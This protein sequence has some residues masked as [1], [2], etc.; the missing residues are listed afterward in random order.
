M[1]SSSSLYALFTACVIT[2]VYLLIFRP[3]KDAETLKPRDA[4]PLLLLLVSIAGLY[5]ELVLIRWMGTEV[6]IFA[7]VQNLV[8]IACFLGFGVGCFQSDKPGTLMPVLDGLVVLTLIVSLPSPVWQTFMLHLSNLLS[9]SADAALWGDHMVVY[10]PMQY[11][12]YFAM[13]VVVVAALLWVIAASMMPLGR[14]IGYCFD[15][16]KNIT[17]TYSVNLVGSLIG[18]WVLVVLAALSMPPAV[19]VTLAFL[20]ILA[21]TPK[22]K[23]NWGVGLLFLLP[24]LIM[25]QATSVRTTWSPYQK[26]T[27]TPINNESEYLIETNNAGYMTISNTQPAFLKRHPGIEKAYR[28]TAYD[29]PFRFA[30]PKPDVLIVG[31]GAGNDASAALRAGASHVDAVE[32]DPVIYDLG[33]RLHPDKP[34]QSAKVDVIINDAR[35]FLRRSDKK[36]DAIIFGLLDSHTEVSGYTNIRVDNYVYTKEAFEQARRLLKPDG[37]LALKFEVR[38]PWEWIGQRFYRT[39]TDVF[40]GRKPLVYAP[41]TAGNMWSGTV[42]LESNSDKLWQRAKQP[43]LKKLIADNPPLFTPEVANAPESSTDDWPYPYHRGRTIPQTY[44]TVSALLLV[45]AF[46]MVRKTFDVRE[47]QTWVMFLLG[48]GFML[49]ETQLVSRLSL[50]FGTTWIVN[51]IAISAVLLVLVLANV[52]LETGKRPDMRKPA[53]IVLI[54]SLIANYFVPWERMPF[55]PW[56]VG[57]ILSAAF[58]VSILMAGVIFTTSLQK[59]EKKSGALGANVMGAVLGGLSQNLSFVIGLKAL[60]PLAAVCYAASAIIAKPKGR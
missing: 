20:V 34:Y 45:I 27:L 40:D 52:Y 5:V 28:D 4:T 59:A 57:L 2:C 55:A 10:T 8:L 33:K 43:D 58:A 30:N 37:I 23:K 25:I 42:Y 56:V 36:Y 13:A 46:F 19:W 60:L 44:L 24:V 16:S 22:S 26:L 53:Y 7:Y 21:A 31:A 9:L 32:I 11:A 3:R 50:Y 14:W 35:N 6:R 49:M 29:S 39:L 48:A 15:H 1:T 17:R 12:G 38:K 47:R 54:L 41:K 51:S 18:T